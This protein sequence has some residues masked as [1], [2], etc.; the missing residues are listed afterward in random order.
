MEM[1][2]DIEEVIRYQVAQK[3]IDTIPEEERKK[4]LEASLAKTL[5]EALKPWVIEN[6]I[7]KDVEK[8]MIEYLKKS[9]VQERVR[10]ATEEAVDNLMNGVISVIIS[11]SQDGIKSSYVKF[12]KEEEK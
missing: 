10:K 1:N 4:I 8:Y 2:V 3:I 9:E 6:V 5:H 11:K 12:L 7:K